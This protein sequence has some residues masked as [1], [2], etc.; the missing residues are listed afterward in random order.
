MIDWK[1]FPKEDGSHH[2]ENANIACQELGLDPSYRSAVHEIILQWE[3]QASAGYLRH[4]MKSG[5]LNLCKSPEDFK[6]ASAIVVFYFVQIWKQADGSVQFAQ[7]IFDEI[8]A[9]RITNLQAL[10]HVCQ[11]VFE[12]NEAF[13]ASEEGKRVGSRSGEQYPGYVSTVMREALEERAGMEL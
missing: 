7:A 12:Q 5:I 13:R 4:F 11:R 6:Q 9:G 2:T 8:E 10:E 1:V 3:A